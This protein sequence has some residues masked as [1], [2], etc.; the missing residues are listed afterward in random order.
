VTHNR[1]DTACRVST[2]ILRGKSIVCGDTACRVSTGAVDVFRPEKMSF[3]NIS[4]LDE[5]LTQVLDC[6]AK[7]G[8]MHVVDKEEL[9]AGLKSASTG[10]IA[11]K[12]EERLS[13]IESAV[14]PIVQRQAQIL[15]EIS[16]LEE[17][18]RQLSALEAQDVSVEDLREMRFL[19]FAFGDVPAEYYDRLAGSLTNVSC[20]LVPRGTTA[21]RQQIL[22]FALT[23]GKE[24]LSNALEAAYFS[25][26]R[27][28]EKYRGP[29]ADVLDEIELEIWTRREEMAELRGEI[30]SLRQRW[31]GKLL[32]LHTTIAANQ[33][34]IESVG[35][36]G[37][38]DKSYFLSG[39]VPHK[40]VKRLQKELEEIAAPSGILM[41]AGEPITAQDAEHYNSKIPTKLSNPFFLRPFAGLIANFGVPR[42]SD[43]DPTPFASLAF[44]AMFGIMF[45][46]ATA[47][48]SGL[49]WRSIHD[50][51]LGVW[52]RFRQGGDH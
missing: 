10:Q 38:T 31:R 9:R 22:A 33:V 49:L 17:N 40:D 43:I 42:Y 36:F 23:S 19:H 24:T 46:A 29:I 47:R 2:G 48:V 4:V 7:L 50:L 32:E 13:E 30:R 35:K 5:H 20:V 28:P 41:S 25:K 37:K 21:G 52:Q 3:V 12:I 45:A 8:A 15:A 34:V 1:R 18:S 51:R 27:I 26:A 11:E 14:N 44:L 16:D 39:W 6:L